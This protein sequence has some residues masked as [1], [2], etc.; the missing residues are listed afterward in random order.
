MFALGGFVD[1]LV[2]DPL[3]AV[4]GDLVAHLA[5]GG[6][7]LGVA[8]QRGAHTEDGERELALFKFTQDAPNAHARSVLVDALHAHMP[9]GVSRRVEHLGEK[10]LGARIAMQHGVLAALFVI[11]DELH[12]NAGA[13]G[14]LGVGHLWAVADQVAGVGG[15]GVVS[16][17][18]RSG[19]CQ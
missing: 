2:V 8:L 19:Q 13:A 14:P 5:Q 4:A 11:E 17:H 6:G 18:G 1:A 15:G 10:L 3:P 7:E 16:A 12:G 9:L